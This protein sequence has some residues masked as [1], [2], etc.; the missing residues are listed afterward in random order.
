MGLAPRWGSAPDVYMRGTSRP[1]RTCRVQV[2]A[3][4]QRQRGYVV[5]NF[6]AGEGKERYKHAKIHATAV[7]F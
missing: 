7:P 6:G 1:R 4:K 2:H 3:E 5:G